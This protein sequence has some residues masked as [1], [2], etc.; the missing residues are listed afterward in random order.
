M[1]APLLSP[2]FFKYF[3]C[4]TNTWVMLDFLCSA[5]RNSH[6][7]IEKINIS[8][9]SFYPWARQC[10]HLL[11]LSPSALSASSILITA[12]L[13]RRAKSINNSANVNFN[14]IW[15]LLFALGGNCTGSRVFQSQDAG[16]FVF[17]HILRLGYLNS[18]N[19][20]LKWVNGECRGKK[21]K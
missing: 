5:P 7:D 4:T 20:R 13:P 17:W 12:L 16:G 3:Q 9:K 15:E 10:C 19:W 8:H 11:G 18:N 14:F 6:S 21:Q 2:V 1:T